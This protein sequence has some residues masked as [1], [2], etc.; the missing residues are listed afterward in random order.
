MLQ[1]TDDGLTMIALTP[2]GSKAFV[3]AQHGVKVDLTSFVDREL[4][5]PPRYILLDIHRALF[6]TLSD[7]PADGIRTAERAGE[8]VTETWKGGRLVSR[9]F[10]RLDGQPVGAIDVRFPGGVAPGEIPAAIELDNG[11]FGY[12]LRIQ[13]L[14]SRPLP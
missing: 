12:A 3:L 9:R 1:L 7:P 6:M 13:T 4:P 14:S 10:V 11:W 2:Y 8:R 5:F